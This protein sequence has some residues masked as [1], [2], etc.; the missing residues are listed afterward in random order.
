MSQLHLL[1]TLQLLVV[2]TLFVQMGGSQSIRRT[3]ICSF[4][5]Q[6]QSKRTKSY[7]IHLKASNNILHLS[8][9]STAI[10]YSISSV[11]RWCQPR[12]R[13]AA[14]YCGICRIIRVSVIAQEIPNLPVS[15]QWPNRHWKQPES[16]PS[17]K[18]L[19]ERFFLRGVEAWKKVYG[20]RAPRRQ[21]CGVLTVQLLV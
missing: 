6:A 3:R 17:F 14:R 20:I 4:R 2:I 15:G 1:R 9:I 5:Y 8:A 10:S 21:I 12:P 7:Q 11:P 16:S 13:A 19:E 18:F